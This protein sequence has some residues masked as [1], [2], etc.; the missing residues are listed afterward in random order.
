MRAFF[1]LL[2]IGLV[3]CSCRHVSTQH[4][5]QGGLIKEAG[6]YISAK[7][8]LQIV[9]S[10]SDNLLSFTVYNLN[11]KEIFTSSRHASTYQNWALFLDREHRLWEASSD[12]GGVVWTK[13]RTG[14]YHSEKITTSMSVPKEVRF[15][16]E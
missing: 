10:D 6:T 1:S 7:D 13:D 11:G 2:I 15:G 4:N 14:K 9:V 8:S 12:I 3:F 5:W 16:A